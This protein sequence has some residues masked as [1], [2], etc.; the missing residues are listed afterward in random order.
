MKESVSVGGV[1]V[2]LEGVDGVATLVLTHEHGVVEIDTVTLMGG[3]L[4]GVGVVFGHGYG[5]VLLGGA[6]GKEQNHE[7][8]SE[9]STH[10]TVYATTAWALPVNAMLYVSWIG[11]RSHTCFSAKLLLSAVGRK[12]KLHGCVQGCMV[13]YAEKNRHS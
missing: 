4:Q 9:E 2:L 7:Q 1:V 12:G 13:Y 11:F 8:S 6:G 5:Y 10:G 3:E